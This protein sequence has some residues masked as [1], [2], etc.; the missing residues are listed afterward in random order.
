MDAIDATVVVTASGAAAAAGD[1][2]ATTSAAAPGAAPRQVTLDELRARMEAFVAERDWHQYHTPRNLLLALTGEVG[3]LA[4]LMQ[5]RGEVAPGLPG[6]APDDV[7]KVGDELADVQL[8]LVRLADV[9][10]VDLGRAVLRKL[11]VNAR[12][13]PAGASRG[14]AAKYTAYVKSPEAMAAIEAEADAAVARQLGGGGSG[15]PERSPA[16]AQAGAAATKTQQQQQ[17]PS[18]PARTALP[19]FS[20]S[21]DDVKEAVGLFVLGGVSMSF[22]AACAI[23]VFAMA[24]EVARH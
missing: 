24:R 3:E 18:A 1:T 17:Q 6:W 16:A 9:C 8:Y 11:E 22:V 2:Q 20:V 12:K 13:Y 4:E 19:S 15:A 14:R 10:G 23:G 21:L 7:R 5:W